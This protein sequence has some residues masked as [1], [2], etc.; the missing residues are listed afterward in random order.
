[1]RHDRTPVSAP[2]PHGGN[3]RRGAGR[4]FT[5]IELL[6]AIVVVGLLAAVALPSFMDSVRKSRRTDAFTALNAVQLAQERWRAN[7]PQYA[8]NDELTRGV[9]ATPPGLGLGTGT[10][11]GYYT[12]ALSDASATGYAATATAVSGKSQANDGTC[13]RLRV[14]AAGGNIFYGSAPAGSDTFDETAGNR[15]WAR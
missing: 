11:S 10:A 3:R 13:V 12:L 1:M 8:G 2:A 15:C 5:L 4:G 6:I 14:R 7:R 9:N